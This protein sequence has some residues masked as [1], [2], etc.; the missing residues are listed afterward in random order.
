MEEG[1]GVF[2]ILKGKP[3]ARYLVVDG[4]TILEWSLI[5]RYQYE[6]LRPFGSG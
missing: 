5:N 4:W 6:E 3:T 2:K 1:R